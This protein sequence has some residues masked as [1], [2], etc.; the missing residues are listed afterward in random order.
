MEGEEP[1]AASD[2]DSLKGIPY[3][4][5]AAAAACAAVVF[6]APGP[7]AADERPAVAFDAA[8]T[9]PTSQAVSAALTP[10]MLPGSG[11]GGATPTVRVR[12]LGDRFEVAAAGQTGSF[13][14]AARDCGERA[15]VAAVFIGLALN[16]PPLRDRPPVPDATPGGAPA[17]VTIPARVPPPHLRWMELGAGLRVDG[18]SGGDASSGAAF[19]WGGEA[20]VAAGRGAFGAAAAAGVLAPAVDTFSSVRVRQQRFPFSLALTARRV[21]PADLLVDGDLGVALALFTAHAEGLAA[22][23]PA[24]RLDVGARA[25]LGLRLPRVWNRL[26]PVVGLHAEYFPRPYQLE[27][28]PI[29]HIGSSSRWWLGGAVGAAFD[30]P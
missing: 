15:R 10:V 30:A 12:D 17:A 23:Q 20:R 6:V 21:L 22:P 27:V 13:A 26:A 11:A 16:P 4:R 2:A 3:I 5:A 8:G 29:G 24:T 25:A 14:D 28:D 19:V 9:C 18:G 7:A 1:I